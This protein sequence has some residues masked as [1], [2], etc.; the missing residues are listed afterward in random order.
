MLHKTNGIVLRSVKYGE[1]SLVTTI[2]TAHFGLQTYMVKGV[3]SPKAKQGRAGAFQPGTLLELVV[4]HHPQKNIQSISQYQ[5]AYIYNGLQEDVVKNS[6]VLF[7]VEVLLRL[8]PENAPLPPLFEFAFGY[9]LALDK[10]TV[11]GV[12]NFPLYFIIVCG[13]I[14]GFEIKGNYTADTPYLNLEDGEFSDVQQKAA[15]ALSQEDAM[16]LDV[17]L[18]AADFETL[19]S[20]KLNGTTR[21]RLIDWY[22]AFLQLHTDHMGNIRSLSV[23]RVIMH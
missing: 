15:S 2:F 16:S 10:M 4:Y 1:T 13:R 23:L 9:Y 3:R 6:I 11:A 7:S 22:I 18:R 8:L 21:M 19:S 14:L 17:L 12:A 20:I 5:A